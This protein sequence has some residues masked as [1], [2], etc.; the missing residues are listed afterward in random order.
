MSSKISILTNGIYQF[1][2]YANELEKTNNLVKIY[3]QQ[4]ILRILKC[5]KSIT[6]LKIN[7]FKYFFLSKKKKKNIYR[8]K[9]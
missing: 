5:K 1:F 9:F 4:D 2:D 6:L 7:N 3:S 8:R